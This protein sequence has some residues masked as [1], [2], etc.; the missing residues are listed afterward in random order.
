MA[1]RALF[2]S[3]SAAGSSDDQRVSDVVATLRSGFDLTVAQPATPT[4][5]AATLASFR[6]DR[7]VVAGGDGSL[8]LTIN[9]IAGLGRLGDTAIGLIP[10]GT[11]NDFAK[12]AGISEDPVAAARACLD[13]APAAIDAIVADDGELVVNAAHAGVGAVA[14]ERAQATKPFAG[15]LA[16]PLGA[17]QAAVTEAGYETQLRLDDDPIYAG[18]ML[19]TLVA[20]G[21]CIGGGTRLCAN[22]DASDGLLDVVLIEAIPLRERLGLG[23]DIQRGTHLRRRDVHQ[24]R[25]RHVAFGGE[26]IDHNRDGEIRHGL[27][28]VTYTIR[29]AA[30]H[31][32]Q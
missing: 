3:S 21:P 31:L 17:I 25:G 19:F 1:D 24:W 5:L 28:D 15:R 14:A 26:P 8:H 20:N 13:A 22:A 4:Q 30:W 10:L 12:G 9:A 6:G 7:V 29:P 27:D 2:V 18:A 16:Y 11:G 23:V 32:M